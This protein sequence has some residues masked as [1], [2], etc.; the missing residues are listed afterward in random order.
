MFLIY[1]DLF[2]IEVENGTLLRGV[3][4]S[5]KMIRGGREKSHGKSVE[6]VCIACIGFFL[7]VLHVVHLLS[8][9]YY[10]YYYS[11]NLQFS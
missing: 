8:S 3:S 6:T 1:S 5:W 4:W 2:I 11:I 10:Y 7:I 9:Y